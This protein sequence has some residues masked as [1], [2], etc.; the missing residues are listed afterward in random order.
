MAFTLA[1]IKTQVRQ[2][3]DMENSTFIKDDELKNYIN[4]SY[5]ELYDI[6]VSRFED[7][8]SK[9]ESFSLTGASNNHS[10]PSDLYKVRGVDYMLST[11]DPVTLR[12]WNFDE[13]NKIARTTT[14]ALRGVGDRQYR[15]MGQNLT[16]LPSDK[17]PGNYQLWYIPRYNP[18]S[19]DA[20]TLGDVLDFA[21][22]II[23]DAAIKCLIKEESDTSV[24]LAIKQG[25]K[26]R[27]EAMASNRDTQPDRIADVSGYYDDGFAYPW[28]Y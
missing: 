28:G 14:R 5:A 2:R 3:A 11:N 22:Y 12:R 10:L 4:N 1:D 19:L 9:S 21:E 27:I 17:A 25:L 23:V 6:L 8:F 26:A 20:D 13:R 18:L 15:V 7:Y 16:V 24:L